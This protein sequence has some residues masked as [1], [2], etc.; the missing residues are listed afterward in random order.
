MTFLLKPGQQGSEITQGQ[1]NITS[2]NVPA[3]SSYIH[4]VT[5]PKATFKQGYLMMSLPYSTAV[6]TAKRRSVSTILFTTDED[7]ATASTNTI[8]RYAIPTYPSGL[9]YFFD[10]WRQKGWRFNADGRL[11]ELD[12]S[13][14]SGQLMIKRCWI[15]GA[16]LKIEFTN[17]HGSIAAKVDIQGSYHAFE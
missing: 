14:A 12:W 6:P 5:L 11:S 4:E 7:D 13:T 17:N 16:L 15:D 1:F 3:A 8:V 9:I 2:Q 10:D